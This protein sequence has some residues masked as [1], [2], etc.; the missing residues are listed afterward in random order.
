M[1]PIRP[2]RSSSIHARSGRGRPGYA[3]ALDWLDKA[4]GELPAA[5]EWWYERRTLIRN[6]LAAGEATL[7]YGAAD[8]YPEGPEG[9]LVEARFHAGWIALSFL[10]DA[11]AAKTHS[12]R[13]PLSTLPNSV[14]QANY[15]L[16][17][18]R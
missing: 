12:S 15:W 1:R 9:R 10:D 2:I 11:E 6:L 8:T 4:T 17:R 7:A 14:T 5:E 3:S 13:W 16:G 18:A